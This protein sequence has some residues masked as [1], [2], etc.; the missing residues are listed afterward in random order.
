VICAPPTGERR[1]V[2]DAQLFLI[3]RP[4]DQADG[5]PFLEIARTRHQYVP[6][7]AV[8]VSVARVFLVRKSSLPAPSTGELNP[9]SAAI[10][11][12]YLQ[13]RRPSTRTPDE[14]ADR[15]RP[16][17]SGSG[18]FG[19]ARAAPPTNRPAAAAGQDAD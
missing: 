6:F 19:T 9:A 12:S 1:V 5:V 15:R 3:D 4:R 8:W 14:A 7:G 18:T 16:R 17:A 2:R 11:N 10:S 13:H